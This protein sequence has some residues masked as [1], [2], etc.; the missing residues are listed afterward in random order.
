VPFSKI[1][2]YRLFFLIISLLSVGMLVSSPHSAGPDEYVHQATAYYDIR[3]FPPTTAT[4][5]DVSVPNAI[6]APPCFAF[7]PE[8]TK[9]C[10]DSQ[11]LEEGN[12]VTVGILNYPPLFYWL[13]GSGQLAFSN[14]AFSE[15]A[16]GGRLVALLAC[17]AMVFIGLRRLSKSDLNFLIPVAYICMTPMALFLFAT[18]NPSGFEI[19]AMFLFVTELLLFVKNRVSGAPVYKKYL[20]LMLATLLACSARPSTFFWVFFVVASFTWFHRANLTLVNIKGIFASC[21]PGVAVGAIYFSTH[22]STYK[23][24]NYIPDESRS[25]LHVFLTTFIDSVGA[26]FERLTQAYGQLG[27]LDTVPPTVLLM[28][29]LILWS[30][31]LNESILSNARIRNNFL[32]TF[33][34]LI[35]II[36]VIEYSVARSWPHFW[37]GRYQLPV[38]MAVIMIF[39]SFAGQK[40]QNQMGV[41]VLVSTLGNIYMVALNYFRYTT[42]VA[43]GFP[44]TLRG[45]E[46]SNFETFC[47]LTILALVFLI[48]RYGIKNKKI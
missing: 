46:V 48:F 13:V 45:V 43:D 21:L 42:G 37:Q 8:I 39:S 28:S 31:W 12:Y 41:I 38:F 36:A 44:I 47:L 25:S 9:N 29:L 17:L 23:L 5:T 3:H 27:W 26:T 16:I 24:P 34:V 20:P 15:Q 32:F 30:L 6:G 7:R 11:N 35:V 22:R 4:L 19:A 18:A 2:D 1:F 10:M 33:G 40:I 14:F